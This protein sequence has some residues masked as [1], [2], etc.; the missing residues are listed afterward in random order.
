MTFDT[1]IIGGGIAGWQAA[2]QLSRCLRKVAVIDDGGGRS[3]AAKMYRNLLGFPSG[4]SGD[5]L[6]QAGRSHAVRFGAEHFED[7]VISLT[8]DADQLFRVETKR[9]RNAIQARTIVLATGIA[10]PF[11]EIAGL[12]ECLG[13]SVF[14]CPDCDGFET[15]RKK[16]AVIGKAKQAVRMADELFYYTDKLHLFISVEG[17]EKSELDSVKDCPYPFWLEPVA[18]LEHRDGE[19]SCLHL[20]NGEQFALSRVFLA[21]PGARVESHLLRAF[22]VE[23]NEKG[24][25]LVNPRTKETSYPGIWAIGDVAAHSQQVAIAMGDGSQAA[26]W[27]H[28]RLL[29]QD[30]K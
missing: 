15:V 12:Q 10:D 7:Q 25:V 16:T 24:H 18:T 6:R 20:A 26:I 19:V 14:I 28:K 3:S 9:G 5:E 13:I 17:E 27:I 8:Q 29:Q 22:P 23:M 1:V 2:I 11:P 30:S 21:F 4:I